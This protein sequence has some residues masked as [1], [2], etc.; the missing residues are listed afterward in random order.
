MVNSLSQS[1]RWRVE[2]LSWTVDTNENMNNI[3]VELSIL[4]F[5]RKGRVM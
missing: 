2:M 5:A 4:L 3:K 1:N